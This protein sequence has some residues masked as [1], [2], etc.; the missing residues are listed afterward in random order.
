MAPPTTTPD[1]RGSGQTE[2]QLLLPAVGTGAVS[3]T[4]DVGAAAALTADDV[5]AARDSEEEDMY[6]VIPSVLENTTTVKR[7][8]RFPLS[9]A[10]VI[11]RIDLQSKSFHTQVHSAQLGPGSSLSTPTTGGGGRGISAKGS[12]RGLSAGGGGGG[13]GGGLRSERSIAAMFV[14]EPSARPPSSSLLGVPSAT[15]A[16]RSPPQGSSVAGDA[17]SSAVHSPRGLHSTACEAP[18]ASAK[19]KLLGG[20]PETPSSQ[21]EL[22]SYTHRGS[23]AS[24]VLV[25]RAR[26]SESTC[27]NA[28]TASVAVEEARQE[29]ALVEGGA[30]DGDSVSTPENN[31]CK[32][33]TYRGAQDDFSRST[34]RPGGIGVSAMRGCAIA[35]LSSMA[36]SLSGSIISSETTCTLSNL[37]TTCQWGNEGLL[38]NVMALLQVYFGNPT[39][40]DAVP[41]LR[42]RWRE[43]VSMTEAAPAVLAKLVC[44]ALFDARS[45]SL[46][47]NHIAAGRSG[48][49]IVSRCPLPLGEAGRSTREVS[50]ESTAFENGKGENT[51]EHTSRNPPSLSRGTYR[52]EKDEVALKL[53]EKDDFDRLRGPAV[54][55]EVLALRALADVPGVCRLYDFGVTLDSYVLV[56]ERCLFSLKD[57]RAAR[58]GGGGESGGA[59]D[60]D[61]GGGAETGAP[62]SDEEAALY[63]LVFRQI[64]SAV[65]AMAERGIIHFDLKCDNVLVRGGS[66][67][68]GRHNFPSAVSAGM[69]R[70]EEDVPSVCV[71]DFGES[72]IGQRRRG[73][74]RLKSSMESCEGSAG[75]END[76]F[77]FDVRNA[78]GTE[79][80][81]SPEMIILATNRGDNEN[82]GDIAPPASVL[83]AQSSQEN[84]TRAR[85]VTTA[86]DVWSLG[87]LLYELISNQLLFQDLQWSE[88]FVTLTSGEAADVGRVAGAA[89]ERTPKPLLP[90]PGSLPFAAL[91][92][93]GVIRTLLESML[94]R[95]PTNRPSASQTVENI[96]KTLAIMV[97]SKSAKPPAGEAGVTTSFP[98]SAGKKNVNSLGFDRKQMVSTQMPDG[99]CAARSEEDRLGVGLD[100]LKRASAATQDTSRARGVGRGALLS[101]LPIAEAAA[102]PL[103]PCTASLVHRSLAARQLALLGCA[104]LLYRLGAG[105]FLLEVN[106]QVDLDDGIDGGNSHSS[107]GCT[108]ITSKT[109]HAESVQRGASVPATAGRTPGGGVDDLRDARSAGSGRRFGAGTMVGSATSCSGCALRAEDNNVAGYI[110]S[111]LGRVL[112]ALGIS[113]VVCVMPER[114]RRGG[115]DSVARGDE[116]PGLGRKTS[117]ED[118]ILSRGPLSE[119]SKL[120]PSRFVSG[121]SRLLRVTVPIEGAENG[122]KESG[123]PVF[124][125]ALPPPRCLGD[126]LKFATGSRV[127][128]VGREVDGGGAGALAVA[129]VMARTGKGAYETVLDFRQSCVGFWVSPSVLNSVI[130]R[131]S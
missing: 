19:T 122:E 129:W 11:P 23:R 68:G 45:Y 4:R 40:A 130:G 108:L 52:C 126:V 109:A 12:N 76:F 83:A 65:A 13:G 41:S 43:G 79:R 35:L 67:P 113:H 21:G 50:A 75:P 74:T 106:G 120:G 91:R 107:G 59:E 48:G 87:C 115:E 102:W 38:P 82:A 71:A 24:R 25:P 28:R 62:R 39:H 64:T 99:C 5:E 127:V 6:F 31:L 63:L 15:L 3:K 84:R 70:I 36:S 29:P 104:G 124:A 9:Q 92:S 7:P 8:C 16:V 103:Q 37:T 58:G 57:W 100:A 119:D 55:I 54:F 77:E 81:Q 56:M 118:P 111:P 53:V 66:G 125:P 123:E 61:G 80:V 96:D 72:I 121:G 73:A 49:V 89:G 105:A 101:E 32:K 117:K 33:T 114:E 44:A 97:V 27:G 20:D 98:T 46:D 14:G 112:P 86:S 30:A 51:P 10:S 60:G 128:F 22:P 95:N 34:P 69:G 18:L 116:D 17:A 85:T 110:A 93:A 90:P 1:S 47:G 42:T 88:F 2:G 26:S 131:S 94:V 78:R